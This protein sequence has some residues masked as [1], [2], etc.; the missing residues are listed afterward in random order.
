MISA[1]Q[2]FE[3]DSPHCTSISFHIFFFIIIKAV[4][5][6]ILKKKVEFGGIFSSLVSML[7]LFIILIV[8]D[9]IF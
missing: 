7:S 2:P 9:S 4:K 1:F 6:G 5:V 8:N 3:I